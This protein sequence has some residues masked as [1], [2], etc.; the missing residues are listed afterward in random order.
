MTTVRAVHLPVCHTVCNTPCMHAFIF[1]ITIVHCSIRVRRVG[2]V[3]CVC[4]SVCNV[5]DAW[6]HV[7]LGM[8]LCQDHGVSQRIQQL[9]FKY[10]VRLSKNTSRMP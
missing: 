9:D 6:V 3:M 8:H 4:M 5:R 2:R 7:S 10:T 1:E